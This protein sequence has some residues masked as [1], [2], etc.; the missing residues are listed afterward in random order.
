MA[1]IA[2]SR[3]EAGHVSTNLDTIHD[4]LVHNWTRY[5]TWLGN[6]G[7]PDLREMF[8]AARTAYDIAARKAYDR[9]SCERVAPV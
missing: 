4:I 8:V 7:L 6:F 2:R 1:A 3:H 5:R 9:V